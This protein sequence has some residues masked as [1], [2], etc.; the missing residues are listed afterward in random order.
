[1]NISGAGIVKGAPNK[2]M[3]LNLV[4]IFTYKRSTNSYS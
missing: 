4:G 1:M 3:Q 2:L